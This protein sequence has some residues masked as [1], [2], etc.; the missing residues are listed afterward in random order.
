MSRNIKAGKIALPMDVRSSNDVPAF[1]NMLSK[2]PMAVV[3]VYADW[4]G[5]CTNYKKN[6]WS[7]LKSMKNRTVNMASVHYDQLEN[8]SLKNSKIDGYPSLLLVGQDKKPAN[9][10]ETNAMPNAND[11]NTMKKVV[12]SPKANTVSS[13]SLNVS[14]NSAKNNS[15]ILNNSSVLNNSG[16][17][18]NNSVLTT[19]NSSVLNNSGLN[20]NNSVLTTNNSS[21]LNNS[22]LNTNNSGLTTNNSS[23]LNNSG[24]NTNTDFSA[25]TNLNYNSVLPPSIDA[26][27]I[28]ETPETAISNQIDSEEKA[29]PRVRTSNQGATP[30]LRG[31]RLYRKLSLKKNKRAHRK[32]TKK[33]KGSRRHKQRK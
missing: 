26:D 17:N 22:G 29:S 25:S 28:V 18:T 1:E 5:H 13:L 3:L 12:A 16:L 6:V 23:V 10:G 27:E 2:G 4:C 33:S 31:G 8:T 21:V 14:N 15:G 32:V 30:L 9:F 19:N 20:T 7:P 24:L 11:I